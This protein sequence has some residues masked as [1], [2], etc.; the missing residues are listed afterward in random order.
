[1]VLI[2]TLAVAISATCIAGLLHAKSKQGD[3]NTIVKNLTLCST[4]ESMSSHL[5]PQDMRTCSLS[6]RMRPMHY[7]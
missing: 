5:F 3:N 1:M 7:G 2:V 6:H 4:S